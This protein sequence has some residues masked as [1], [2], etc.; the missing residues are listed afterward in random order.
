MAVVVLDNVT[1]WD[2][3]LTHERLS[4]NNPSTVVFRLHPNS[5]H[6]HILSDAKYDEV[7]DLTQFQITR[8]T[9]V[10]ILQEEFLNQDADFLYPKLSHL[11]PPSLILDPQQH[12]ELV[13]QIIVR[14]YGVLLDVSV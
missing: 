10:K 14:A 4:R 13:H 3:G 12:E 8:L 11:L 9:S 1:M 5:T 2:M 7:Q 6:C